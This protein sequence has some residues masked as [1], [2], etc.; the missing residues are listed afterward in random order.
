MERF[1]ITCEV[2]H[3][4]VEFQFDIKKIPDEVGPCYMV[5]V[6]GIF[7]GYVRKEKSG[8]FGQLMNSDFTSEYMS[9]INEQLKLISNV[10]Q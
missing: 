5:S 10:K 2:S 3:K 9:I 7:R 4:P 6:D 1:K 8:I